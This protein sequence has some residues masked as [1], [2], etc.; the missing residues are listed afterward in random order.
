MLIGLTGRAG[1]GKSTVADFMKPLGFTEVALSD[2]LKR[3]CRDVFAFNDEQLWGPSACRDA[4]DKRYSHVI[5]VDAGEKEY[6]YLT[7]RHALQQLGTQWGRACYDNVWIDLALRTAGH[8][9]VDADETERDYD[10]YRRHSY[11]AQFGLFDRGEG[12]GDHGN[13][14]R[15]VVI[16]DVRFRNEVDAIIAAG[17]E[18][19][20]IVRPG[21][22][23]T[24][25]AAAHR[26][27]LELSDDD[28]SRYK[29]VIYNDSSLEYLKDVVGRLL[30]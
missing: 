12:E 13:R 1:A 2:P 16:S 15:G 25:A 26:S 10:K 30:T 4:P 7:P 9:L 8:L 27:E 11:T 22:G 29:R 17:G 19:W 23:L 3:I 18:V 24:G 28:L 21:D 6:G 5:G 14:I 20:R